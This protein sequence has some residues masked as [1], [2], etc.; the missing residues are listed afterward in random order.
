[1]GFLPTEVSAPPLS[2]LAVALEPSKALSTAAALPGTLSS[3]TIAKG[4]AV[5]PEVIGQSY[6]LALYAGAGRRKQSLRNNRLPLPGTP[7]PH[8]SWKALSWFL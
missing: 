8:Q 6:T 4:A 5:S 7:P 2:G 3:D 1:M